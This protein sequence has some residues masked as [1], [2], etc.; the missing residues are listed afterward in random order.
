MRGST[1][2]LAAYQTPKTT[3]RIAAKTPVLQCERNAQTI[4]EDVGVE[5]AVTLSTTTV[6][7]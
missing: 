2:P 3:A 5:R 1:C 7:Q 6:S 4:R